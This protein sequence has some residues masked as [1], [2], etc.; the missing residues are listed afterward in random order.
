[1]SLSKNQ[2]R[3]IFQNIA[4]S[5]WMIHDFNYGNEWEMTEVRPG[6]TKVQYPLLYVVPRESVY[7]KGAIHHNYYLYVFDLVKK[8]ESNEMEVESDTF[9]ICSDIVALLN[10]QKFYDITLDRPSVRVEAVMTEKSPD[11]LTGHR[12]SITLTERFAADACA[13]PGEG[14]AQ[15]ETS[16][17]LPVTITINGV[18]FS[19]VSSGQT[20]NIPVKDTDGAAVGEKIGDEW[21]V[22]AASGGGFSLEQYINLQYIYE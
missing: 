20:T 2:I 19:V 14:F 5:H 4:D 11:E 13:V 1:M 15:E 12:M 7:P 8:G 10:S 16:T 21:I 6:E 18:S 22:P 3:S 17:C 9:K